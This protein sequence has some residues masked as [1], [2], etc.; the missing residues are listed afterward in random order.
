M[1]LWNRRSASLQYCTLLFQNSECFD[2]PSDM[3]GQNWHVPTV[4]VDMCVVMY[5][6]HTCHR[7]RSWPC[8]STGPVPEARQ[9]KIFQNCATRDI[10]NP[11]YQKSFGKYFFGRG[12]MFA[13]PGVGPRPA[14]HI[15]DPR[16][17]WQQR[18]LWFSH[19]IVSRAANPALQ[20]Y[21]KIE[22]CCLESEIAFRDLIFA[23]LEPQ[24]C[25]FTIL[26]SFISKFGMF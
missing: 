14:C 13:M 5:N 8:G 12:K 6:V 18:T 26:H 25:I 15:P 2:S 7:H 23:S 17:S 20:W 24:E 11:S 10:W 16:D 19:V 1:L 3:A 21:L 22:F 4:Q 9:K